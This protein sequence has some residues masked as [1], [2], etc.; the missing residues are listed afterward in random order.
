M[1]TAPEVVTQT[2]QMD[3][4]VPY[5]RNPRTIPDEAVNAVGESISRYGYQ[6]PIVVD[7]SGTIVIG[8]TRYA[9]LRRLG[10]TEVSVLVADL[11]PEKIKQLRVLDNRAG[12]LTSWD[13]DALTAELSGLDAGLMAAYF[14]EVDLGNEPLGEPDAVLPIYTEGSDSAEDGEVDFICPAC[15]HS[16]AVHVGSED[17]LKGKIEVKP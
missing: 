5:W 2:M 17:I 8:H 9:A 12:E 1:S 6:Q 15:F 3:E 13:F 7:T 10:V 11:P 16:W 14:P 4:I